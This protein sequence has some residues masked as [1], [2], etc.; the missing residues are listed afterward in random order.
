MSE[1]KSAKLQ[2]MN[3]E[4]SIG[5]LLD[6]CELLETRLSAV[7][8][9]EN[10]TISPLMEE[11]HAAFSFEPEFVQLKQNEIDSTL[12]EIAS[13]QTVL[14]SLN[15]DLAAK[16]DPSLLLAKYF[17][18]RIVN[19]ESNL[20]E[21]KERLESAQQNLASVMARN[22]LVDKVSVEISNLE[23]RFQRC[24]EPKSIL[25]T[26]QQAVKQLELLREDLRGSKV[27]IFELQNAIG[28]VGDTK[29]GRGMLLI[30]RFSELEDDVEVKI[31]L[32]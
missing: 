24:T 16:M 4:R 23:E 12:L 8:A 26:K 25:E 13:K 11:L 10:E 18:A 3:L 29:E 1:L 17:K 2:S 21:A 22:D 7:V 15:N 30:Q 6:Q 5:V 9:S 28:S 31:C 19:E 32:H 14:A 27:R 20:L